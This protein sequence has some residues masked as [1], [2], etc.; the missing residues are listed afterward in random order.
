MKKNVKSILTVSLIFCLISLN[1]CVEP[2]KRE[3]TYSKPQENC[4]YCA[5]SFNKGEGFNT[6][7]RIINKPDLEYSAYCSRK[8]AVDFL[9]NN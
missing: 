2:P 7:M 1:S 9:R 4:D 6:L 8:C 5:K 3:K